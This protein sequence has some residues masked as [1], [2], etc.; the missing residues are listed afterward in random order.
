MRSRLPA[1][2][3]LVRAAGVCVLAISALTAQSVS[4]SRQR[5]RSPREA[6]RAVDRI[7]PDEIRVALDRVPAAARGVVFPG[8]L[9]EG[10]QYD[11]NRRTTPT[12]VE[13]HA[14]WDDVLVFQDGW[15]SVYY[16]GEWRNSQR[17]YQGERRGGSLANPHA[18]AVGPGDVVRIPAGEPHRIV[19][20]GSEPLT[21]LVVKVKR[22]MERGA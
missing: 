10:A 8:S 19:P 9:D 7:G 3:R 16:G 5:A 1:A 18:L 22:S 21:Y 2:H 14:E 4:A 6:A 11:F 13:A 17:I 20:M 12:H 15:G